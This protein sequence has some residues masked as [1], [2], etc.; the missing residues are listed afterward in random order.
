M[1]GRERPQMQA[2][3]SIA[4]GALQGI[5]QGISAAVSQ[6]NDVRLKKMDLDYQYNIAMFARNNSNMQQKAGFA[7]QK[8]MKILD[9]ENATTM[10]GSQNKYEKDII[11]TNFANTKGLVGLN[12]TNQK[13]LVG[14]N[15]GNQKDLAQI[16]YANQ[17]DLVGV[18]FANQKNLT[19]INYAN[20]LGMNSV[21]FANQLN[22]TGVNFNNAKAM[23]AIDLQNQK[24]FY[25]F[26][27]GRA[28]DA[29][30]AG[31]RSVGTQ[32]DYVPPEARYALADNSGAARA[33]RWNNRDSGQVS[34]VVIDHKYNS[35]D[36]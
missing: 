13:D 18:N 17:K 28:N 9:F 14:I 19:R 1:L 23:A 36:V 25:A 12:F 30:T 8:K 15:F 29:R 7:Q 32:G 33:Y 5:G 26:K 2:A 22:L 16:N 35:L 20:S 31:A 10:L 11:A 24:D 3:A 34:G 6:A 4:G 27:T 21:Q